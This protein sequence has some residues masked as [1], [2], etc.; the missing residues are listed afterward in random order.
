MIRWTW[1][2]A[3][4][5]S[6][7]LA[8]TLV[9]LWMSSYHFH[10]RIGHVRREIRY[11]LHLNRGHLRLTA[12]PHTLRST[13]TRPMQIARLVRNDQVGWMV[14]FASNRP[15]HFYPA[16]RPGTPADEMR[17]YPPSVRS[18]PLLCALESRESFIAAHIDLMGCRPQKVDSSQYQNGL[19]RASWSGL[20]VELEA[21]QSTLN[22]PSRIDPAQLP[23]IRDLWH[24]RLDVQMAAMPFWPLTLPPLLLPAAW[25]RAALRKRRRRTL[26]LCPACGYDLRATPIRCPECGQHATVLDAS[27]A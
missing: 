27:R 2:I 16:W 22:P 5:L 24:D 3:C 10:H 19:L 1:N 4:L 11:T 6:L 25:L 12:P 7:A 14:S 8:G 26:G 23:A 9:V 20:Q 18:V 15:Y 13:N 21:R 17:R